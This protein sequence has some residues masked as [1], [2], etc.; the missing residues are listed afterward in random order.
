MESCGMQTLSTKK[1]WVCTG[2]FF[3]FCKFLK[4]ELRLKQN[5]YCQ[6]AKF[7]KRKR[8]KVYSVSFAFRA[9][10]DVKK[11]RKH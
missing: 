10:I 8:K 11:Y 7:F 6:S 5:I 3:D 2:S 4:N 1:N 9:H